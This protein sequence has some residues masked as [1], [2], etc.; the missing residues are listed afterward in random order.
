VFEYWVIDPELETV[1]VFRR[2]GDGYAR[3][4]ELRL[5]DGATL[6]SPLLPGIEMP[7]GGIFAEG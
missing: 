4:A 3:S 1:K 2:A 6:T 7:L 5:E